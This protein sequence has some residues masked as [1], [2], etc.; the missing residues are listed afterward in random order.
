MLDTCALFTPLPTGD[1]SLLK[2]IAAGYERSILTFGTT[3][4]IKFWPKVQFCPCAPANR[5]NLSPIPMCDVIK[6]TY[7]IKFK[8]DVI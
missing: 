2:V 1:K 8:V 6:N 3:T 4:Y 7:R 5:L